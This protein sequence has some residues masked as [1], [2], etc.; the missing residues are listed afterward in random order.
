MWWHN[1]AN[2][3][4]YKSLYNHKSYTNVLC[5]LDYV[6]LS[7]F[8]CV[9]V[10]F[11]FLKWLSFLVL[12]QHLCSCNYIVKDKTDMARVT[13]MKKQNTNNINTKEKTMKGKE[14]KTMFFKKK[15]GEGLKRSILRDH[16]QT[17]TG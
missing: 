11:L 3:F 4:I 6:R 17:R 14:N 1:I 8:L 2:I 9:C 13:D 12:W 15:G 16:I 5:V 10:F 7:V